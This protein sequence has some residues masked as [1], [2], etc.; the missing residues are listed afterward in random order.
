MYDVITVGLTKEQ[1]DYLLEGMDCG[2]NEGILTEEQREEIYCA[3]G[4]G[5]EL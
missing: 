4:R 2:V 5:D 3:L 1:V